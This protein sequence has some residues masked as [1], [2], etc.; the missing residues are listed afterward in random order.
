MAAV[1]KGHL[2]STRSKA[3]VRKAIEKLLHRVDV[4][5]GEKAFPA[6]QRRRKRVV[7]K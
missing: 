6:A 7:A 4:H 3:A 1:E 5:R 2:P